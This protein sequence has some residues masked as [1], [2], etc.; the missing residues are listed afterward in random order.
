MTEPAHTTVGEL[1]HAD[2]IVVAATARLADAAR[3]LDEHRIHGLPVVDEDGSL[4]GV[5]SQ[6]DLVRARATD[7][8]WASWPGL[9]VRHLMTAPALTCRADTPV[10]E[11][12]GLMELNRVH[13]L[14]VVDEEGR[15]PVGIFSTTDVV[16]QLVGATNA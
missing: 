16:H 3:L 5:L 7:Q 6:T 14:V 1:M 13:R 15:R 2:P 8:L 4:A 11:A 12:I 10:Q 9:Q